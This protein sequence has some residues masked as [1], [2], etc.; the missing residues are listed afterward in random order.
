MMENIRL[1]EALPTLYK[2]DSKGNIQ[3][4]DIQVG[5][6]LDG[7]HKGAYA[8]V[9]H[10]GRRGGKIQT[11]IDVISEGKNLGK[12]NETSVKD[13]AVLEAH[14]KWTKQQERKGYVQSLEATATDSRPG[15]EPMLAHRY[16]KHPEK[17]T[18]PCFIQ[19]KLDGHRCIAVIKN[20]KCELFSRKR[21]P[22]TGLPHIQ[23]E[24]ESIFKTIDITLDGELYNHAMRVQCDY[25]KIEIPEGTIEIEPSMVNFEQLSSFIRSA[26]PKEGHEEIQYHI[27]DIVDS[28]M[29]YRLR[30]EIIETIFQKVEASQ[31][32]RQV[33]TL[34]VQTGEQVTERFEHFLKHGYEGAILRNANGM[35]VGTRSYDLQKVKSFEDDEFKIVGVTDGRGKDAGHGI[36]V[37]ETK[38]GAQFQVKQKGEHSALKHIFENPNEYIGKL[39]T[40]QYQGL[41]GA[42]KVPRFPVGLR[43]REDV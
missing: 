12:A 19:P 23:R 22:I 28:E 39:L 37:C 9:V 16:D 15:A 14:A 20:G 25:G 33:E 7:A 35:Y 32:L 18:F 4:W 40:V 31:C 8:L 30:L 17:I 41:T 3:L 2:Q 42:N 29:P 34:N 43:L 6:L 13:Q 10:H 36:Y 27:Y 26:T 38:S 11:G 21:A 24:L 1:I 5:E